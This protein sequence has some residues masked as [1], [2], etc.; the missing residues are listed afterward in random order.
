MFQVLFTIWRR[1]AGILLCS[2]ENFTWRNFLSRLSQEDYCHPRA[3]A[4]VEE[5]WG[6]QGLVRVLLLLLEI[7]FAFGASPSH[8]RSCI[9]FV[10]YT[11]LPWF[12]LVSF[13]RYGCGHWPSSSNSVSG[14]LVRIWWFCFKALGSLVMAFGTVKESWMD[15]WWKE[16]AG[17][18]FRHQFKKYLVCGYVLALHVSNMVEP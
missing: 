2:W 14:D 3:S 7:S 17:F 11:T 6:S 15:A 8:W 10:K 13:H 16:M 5:I 12:E 1:T 9:K 18:K 4:Q